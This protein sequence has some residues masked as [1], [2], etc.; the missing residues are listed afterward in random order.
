[1]ASSIVLTFPLRELCVLLCAAL[2]LLMVR[3]PPLDLL[4]FLKF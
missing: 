4:I 3:V 2:L 1:M